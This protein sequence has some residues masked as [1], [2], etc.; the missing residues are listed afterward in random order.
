MIRN[1]HERELP[2]GAGALI[3]TLSGPDDRLWPLEHWPA[4]RFDRPLSIGAVG[5]HGPVRY[6]VSEYEPGRRIRFEFH[7][8]TGFHGYHEYESTSSR[9]RHTMVLSP[10]GRA[11]VTWPLV[12]RPLHDALV[13]DSL[14]VAARNLGAAG[15]VRPRWSVW[16]RLLRRVISRGGRRFPG[17]RTAR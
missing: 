3:D 12:Y 15:A 5:G 17:A 13:E 9:L 11:R 1:V 7:G 8:P 2:A 14:Y 4:Q 16:V 6:R 10:R